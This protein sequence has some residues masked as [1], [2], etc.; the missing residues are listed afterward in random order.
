VLNPLGLR[1]FPLE[2]GDIENKYVFVPLLV[3]GG[4]RGG[5]GIA[6]SLW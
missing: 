1:P 4:V 5:F 6:S 3:K 2:K